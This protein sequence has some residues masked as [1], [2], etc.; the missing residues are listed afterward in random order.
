MTPY[1]LQ[2]RQK[3]TEVTKQHWELSSDLDSARKELQ[4][5][6]AHHLVN[7]FPHLKESATI[8]WWGRLFE[9]D[10][11]MTSY[12]FV[13]ISKSDRAKAYHEGECSSFLASWWVFFNYHCEP[14]LGSFHSVS[15]LLFLTFLLLL[16]TC[17][18]ILLKW[19]TNINPLTMTN[20]SH[21]IEAS[22]MICSANQLTGFCMI[23]NTGC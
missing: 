7:S 3:S 9:L 18:T 12:S 8:F 22:Q 17:I 2:D 10:V 14:V 20:V 13:A 6:N 16:V 1:R 11:T 15:F 21:H 4:C 19:S 5:L 23:W